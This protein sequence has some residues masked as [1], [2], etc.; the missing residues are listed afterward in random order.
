M[1]YR[2]STRI[3]KTLPL[4]Y[5]GLYACRILP[6]RDLFHPVLPYAIRQDGCPSTKKM[7]VLCRTCAQERNFTL[8]S[9]THSRDERALEGVWITPEIELALEKGYEIIDAF[10]VWDYPKVKTGIALE[11]MNHFLKGKQEAAGWPKNC[12]TPEQRAEYVDA[13]LEREGV[14]LDPAKIGEERNKPLYA[15]NKQ[16]LNCWWGKLAEQQ[17][18]KQTKFVN[19]AQEFF[20]FLADENAKEKKFMFVDEDNLMLYWH[21]K[22][23]AIPTTR[24]GNVVLGAFTTGHARVHLYREILEKIGTRAVYCDTDSGIYTAGQSCGESLSTGSF[25]GD[26]TNELEEDR[27]IGEWVCGGPKNYGYRTYSLVKSP[28]DDDFR[29]TEFKCKGV[30]NTFHTNERVSFD[31]L[32]DLILSVDDTL[33]KMNSLPSN[34]KITYHNPRL[35]IY[36]SVMKRSS[37]ESIS[38]RESWT[39]S[40]AS[41]I[42]TVMWEISWSIDS[43]RFNR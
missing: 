6:Q 19:S 27:V 24:K 21:E 34:E 13:F 32:R 39:A 10:E 1:I 26:L 38:T 37:T 20:K 36:M 25:L 8:N 42:R 43:F 12:T 14:Q 16:A 30:V 18:R 22:D 28:F 5:F 4:G 41:L 33:E 31:S 7:Y 17:Q 35:L 11:Y 23:H 40:Q 29:K 3:R 9:S 15:L 2:N